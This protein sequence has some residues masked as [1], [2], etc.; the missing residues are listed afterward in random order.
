MKV[1]TKHKSSSLQKGHRQKR[2]KQ[3][4]GRAR[5]INR[6]QSRHAF[7]AGL[8][9]SFRG[10]YPQALQIARQTRAPR[11]YTQRDLTCFKNSVSSRSRTYRPPK[12]YF[13]PHSHIGS[14]RGRQRSVPRLSYF[15]PHACLSDTTFYPVENPTS[16]S[17]LAEKRRC[18]D[19][20]PPSAL[21]VS[22]RHNT[23]CREPVHYK[24]VHTA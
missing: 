19:T 3:R 15:S 9:P 10:F 11:Q 12:C 24:A 7:M 6:R 17:P 18:F 2:C 5:Q 4:T 13:N 21:P 20:N 16:I 23:H 1:R 8:D 22:P 14:D